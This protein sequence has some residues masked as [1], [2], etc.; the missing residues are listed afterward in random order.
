MS[1]TDELQFKNYYLERLYITANVETGVLY[2]RAGRRM[3]ALTNDFLIGLHRALEKECGSKTE[4]VL[5]RCG[6]RWGRDFGKG[7][8]AEWTLFYEHPAREFPVAFFQSLLI[9]E[10]GQ[11]GWGLLDL[12]YQYFDKGVIQLSLQGA[13]M[14]DIYRDDITYSADALTAGILAGLFSHFLGRDVDCVQSQCAKQ[15]HSS[16]LFLLSSPE[17]IATIRDQ[18]VD[19]K[20]HA[21][22]LNTLLETGAN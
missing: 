20:A 8:D 18:G 6:K 17:R 10:F 19:G 16:S 22:I 3:L 13:I 1:I 21:N 15:G 7:M 14:S 11:N 2:N 9:Q 5:H 4:Q 12:D